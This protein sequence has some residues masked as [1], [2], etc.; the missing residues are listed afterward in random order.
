MFNKSA[1]VVAPASVA[2]LACGYDLLGLALDCFFFD[3]AEAT[4]TNNKEEIKIVDIQGDGKKL[5][6]DINK[7]TLG[8]SAQ[9]TYKALVEK[10]PKIA[11]YG[12]DL[13]LHKKMPFA[14]GLGSSAASAVAGSLAVNTLFNSPFSKEELLYFC[15]VGE[16]VADGSMHADNVAP[17]LFGGIVLICD[18]KSL[19][20]QKLPILENLHLVLLY[21]HI[22]I[23]TKDCRSII[24][25]EVEL[26]L[27]IR[28]SGN[29]ASFVSA[30]YE[31]DYDLIRQSLKDLIIEPQRKHLIP[32]FDDIQKMAFN[33]SALGSSISGAG[34]SIFS[35]FQSKEQA[36]VF[37]KSIAKFLAKVDFSYDLFSCSIDTLGARVIQ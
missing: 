27:F 35:L 25:K 15:V 6:Y 13:K 1:R 31:E 34:P 17:S 20:F 11:N 14:S 30:L 8:V 33:C 4:L 37:E 24:K 19:S 5:P 22:S 9:L 26:S 7:N 21:P 28:Q 3:E 2:N 36:K 32:N 12:V 16:S 18:S 29:L 23:L 10:N